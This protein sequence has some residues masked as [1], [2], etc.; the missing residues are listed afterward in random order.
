VRHVRPIDL[1][2]N[3]VPVKKGSVLQ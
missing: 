2:K 1:Q 3:D